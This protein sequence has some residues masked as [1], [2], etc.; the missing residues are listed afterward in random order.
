MSTFTESKP[1]LSHSRWKNLAPIVVLIFLSPV[2]A[3]LLTGTVHL[4]NLWLLVPEMGV[5]GFAALMIREVVRRKG[6]GWGTILLLGIA[7]AIA[8]ECVILQTSLTPQFFPPDFEKSFGW[9]NGVQWVYLLAIVWYESVYAI[10]LPIYL[11]EM[12]FP[13]KRDLLWLSRRGLVISGVILLLASIGVW[14]LWSRVGLQ[15]FGPS[16]YQVPPFYIVAALVVIV[17]LVTVTLAFRQVTKHPEKNI[18]RA[19]VPW[20]VGLLAFGFGLLWFLMIGLAFI[21]TATFKGASPVVPMIIGLAWIG[22]GLFV[23]SRISTALNW[24]DRHRLALIF[25]ASIAS[26]LGGT[27]EVLADVPID[28]V[29]KFVVDL[30]A[31]GLFIWFAVRVHKRRF[32]VVQS[33]SSPTS[34]EK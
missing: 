32:E 11:T 1:T 6:R 25:G 34:V 27:L 29:G 23:V 9:A 14:Q 33:E 20:L 5:Y 17:V 28:I 12:L 2:I 8:E 21:P 18:R 19:P 24:Q 10:V 16:T 3:E 22:V 4:T 15:K 31:I 26:M 7:F 30:I 13:S